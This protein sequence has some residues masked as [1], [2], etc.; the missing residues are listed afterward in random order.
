MASDPSFR[1]I[2]TYNKSVKRIREIKS[3]KFRSKDPPSS[4]KQ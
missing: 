1:N 4:C 3:I 2:E